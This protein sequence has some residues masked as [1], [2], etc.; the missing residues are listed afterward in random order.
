M[1]KRKKE[2]ISKKEKKNVNER[3]KNKKQ[4]NNGTTILKQSETRRFKCLHIGCHKRFLKRADVESHCLRTHN[5]EIK[6]IKENK[7]SKRDKSKRSSNKK[8]KKKPETDKLHQPKKKSEKK[9]IVA[10]VKS[11]HDLLVCKE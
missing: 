7:T 8:R 4:K 6:F 2:K 10:K 3:K 1:T 5:G 11:D 9:N